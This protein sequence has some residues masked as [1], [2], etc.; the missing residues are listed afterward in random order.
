MENKSRK[1]L[2]RMLHR[3][4][5]DTRGRFIAITLIIMLG[6]LI[7]VGVKGIGP[8]YR[9]SATSELNKTQLQDIS[10]SSTAGLTQKDIDLAKKIKGVKVEASKNV[11]ALASS[12]KSVVNVYGYKNN[13][14]LNQLIIREGHLPT[15][16]NQIVL[17][18]R[19]KRYGGFKIGDTYKLDKTKGL[20]RQSY[21]V[22]GFADSPLYINNNYN[23]G[24]ANVG[25]GTVSYFA[26]VPENNFNMNVYTSIGIFM[27]KRPSG[28]TYGKTYKNAVDSKMRQVKKVFDDRASQRKDEL[29][30]TA[31]AQ[32]QMPVP[33]SMVRKSI[34]TPT[35]N[36]D[37]RTDLIGFTDYGDSSD[38][39]A[40]IGDVFPVFFFLIAA[41]ITFTTISRM[42][43]EDR[44]QLGTMKAMGY[45]RTKIARNYFLYALLAAIIGTVFG[46]IIGQQGLV[47]FVLKISQ[48]DIFTNQVVYPQWT[49]IILATVMSLVATIGAVAIVAPTELRTKPAELMLPKVPKNGKKILLERIKPFWS[50]LSFNSKVSIRNLFRFK[51]RMFM[52]IIGIAG[53]AGLILTGFGLKDS[54][55]GLSAAQFG[56]VVRYQAIVR[57]DKGHNPDKARNILSKNKSYKSAQAANT[58]VVE[59]HNDDNSLSDVSFLVPSSSK[60][61]SKYVNLKTTKNEKIALPKSGITLSNKAATLMDVEKGDYV[62]IQQSNGSTK[63]VRVSEIVQN[64]IG[65]FAY[66][67][68]TAYKAAFGS[69][70]K[71][72]GLLVKT[73]SM[74]QKSQQAMAQDLLDKGN[75]I[76]TTYMS[77]SLSSSDDMTKSLNGV[78]LILILMSGLLSFVVLYN[79]TNI[80][81]SERMRE[82]STIKVLGFYD[83]EVTL[84]IARE[85]IALTIVGII[86]SFGVGQ[87]LTRF[88]LNQAATNNLLFPTI[89]DWEGYVAA[90]V[91]TAL[92]T[93]IVMYVTHLRLRKVDMLEALASRE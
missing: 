10:I 21:K 25:S 65:H 90:T 75:I 78:V 4:L 77:D 16:P 22:V 17:D 12:D 54:I 6:V 92:F 29:V 68:P 47:R 40:A 76:N 35:Y 82:L 88:I 37:K 36:F 48:S 19:A 56:G 26:Y 30:S 72:N 5:K 71:I 84:Y 33:E 14:S 81:V 38:R 15:Q 23:R 34:A 93:G 41:L 13:N 58:D 74:S 42:I 11:F 89:I 70:V 27:N 55:S 91:L 1:V 28:D 83:R 69:P 85:N 2:N 61:F 73:K 39:I 67:S 31:I 86:F 63:K 9:D 32:Q 52:T 87:L 60:D 7:F 62:K 50:R 80:N 79:L 51:S 53:G 3:T 66:M 57:L 45:S 64:Y 20:T 46:V 8:G 59:L 24:N 49:D 43:S 18:Q 44:T